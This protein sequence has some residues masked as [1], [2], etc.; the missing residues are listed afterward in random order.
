MNYH[1]KIMC[2][3]FLEVGLLRMRSVLRDLSKN[4]SDLP[5]ESKNIK[6]VVF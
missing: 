6:I 2:F 1:L 5:K 4:Q 3:I